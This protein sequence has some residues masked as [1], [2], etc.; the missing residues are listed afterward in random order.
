[1]STLS[2]KKT[3]S[4]DMCSGPLIPKMIRFTLPLMF[5]N[6]IQLLYN[7]ADIIVVGRF[8]GNEALAAVGSTG[9]LVNLLINVFIGLSVGASVTVSK[10]FGSRDSDAISETVHTAITIAAICGVIST[11]IGITFARPL[12]ILM[13]AP[14]DVLDGAV[15]YIKIFF[16]GMPFN[17]VLNFGSAIL[18]AVGDTKR[19]MYF[20]SI[21]GIVN[22]ILNLIFVI[23]MQMSVAGVAIAT[24]IA[25]ALACI[26]VV[27]CLVL[28][29]GPLHL[30]FKKLRLHKDKLK[31]IVKIGLPAGIQGSLFS[32]S[33]VI[34]Q[35]SINTFG[36][37]AVA[38][39]A[40][41]SNIE[42]FVFMAMNSMHQTCISFASQN[43]G[44]KQYARVRQVL[45][46]CLGLVTLVAFIGFVIAFPLR[47]QLLGLYT[48]DPA[49]IE[50]GVVRLVV[51]LVF[52]FL[53]GCMDVTVGHLR[54]IGYAVIPMAVSITGICFFRV[55][56]VAVIFPMYN[57]LLSLY[58]SYPVSWALCFAI[59]YICYCVVIRKTPK[60]N[61]PMKS[62]NQLES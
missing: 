33:N 43:T 20:L 49:V 36:S 25:Q 58:I 53:C 18:R 12:L 7:A 42:G 60:E 47:Y 22:V 30:D 21:S 39:N 52:Y 8:A 9:S 13:D 31:S 38:G 28:S 61:Q 32:V 14:P 46:S 2:S 45:Y 1:M 4:M 29:T 35:S 24:I 54:G 48:T 5:T 16:L 40:A 23:P 6:M 34:I 17:M 56:W 62:D 37:I 10:Y 51:H 50:I 15:L 27:R 44:A 41:S 19:P 59:N 3:Y 55:F 11:F 57:T 26:M